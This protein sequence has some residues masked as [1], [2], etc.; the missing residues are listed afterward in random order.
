MASPLI[1]IGCHGKILFDQE[2][3]GLTSG[4][5]KALLEITIKAKDMKSGVLS[6]I[7]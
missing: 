3:R 5:H 6:D 4:S 2:S 7:S 1:L